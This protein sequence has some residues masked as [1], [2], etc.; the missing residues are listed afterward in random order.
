VDNLTEPED[1]DEKELY[2]ALPLIIL[3][4]E[5]IYHVRD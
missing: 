5:A 2:Y 3:L 4:K 1:E